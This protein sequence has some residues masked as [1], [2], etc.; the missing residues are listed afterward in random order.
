MTQAPALHDG[1]REALHRRAQHRRELRDLFRRMIVDRESAAR[2]ELR[3]ERI[4]D[5]DV[6]DELHERAADY[7]LRADRARTILIAEGVLGIRLSLVR[8]DGQPGRTSGRASQK[9]AS[10]NQLSRSSSWEWP[11][12]S[13]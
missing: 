4:T 9:G 2:L 10:A 7:R 6:V 5:P 12:H 13:A 11:S 3:A 1:Q 8:P